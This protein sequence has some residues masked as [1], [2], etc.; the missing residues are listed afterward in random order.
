MKQN[1]NTNFPPPYNFN[2]VQL[3]IIEPHNYFILPYTSGPFWSHP[4]QV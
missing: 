3:P 4:S 1:L 2:I